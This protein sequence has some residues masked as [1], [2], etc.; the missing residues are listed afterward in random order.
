MI[1]K[2]LCSLL[3]F[4]LVALS[5]C[6]IG[7]AENNNSNNTSID[8]YGDD[9]TD[10]NKLPS[11]SYVY[12]LTENS[13]MVLAK[14]QKIGE[15]L[16]YDPSSSYSNCLMAEFV[17]TED[18]FH[19]LS[20]NTVINVPIRLPI[21]DE[22]SRIEDFSEN[23]FSHDSASVPINQRKQ[24]S[25]QILAEFL[26]EYSQAIIYVSRIHEL[27]RWYR[28]GDWN[29]SVEV[30]S[31]SNIIISSYEFIPIKEEFVTLNAIKDFYITNNC[32]Y[33]PPEKCVYGFSDFIYDGMT[34]KTVKTN[35]TALYDAQT[36]KKS[37]IQQTKSI[38]A[39]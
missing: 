37:I 28:N 13:S 21:T 23:Y 33:N 2:L 35:I 30:N 18:Y 12:S 26:K 27:Q 24:I 22:L 10:E 34:L 38:N 15:V 39:D 11:L 8:F 5:A 36:N 20:K 14:L 3:C 17:I 9:V 19:H 32:V 4:S 29:D 25:A 1:K 6:Q 31:V 7:T 16:S